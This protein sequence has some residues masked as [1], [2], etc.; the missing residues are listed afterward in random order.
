MQNETPGG[1]HDRNVDRSSSSA[2]AD[3]DEPRPE[4]R[5][6]AG[7]HESQALKQTA[8]DECLQAIVAIWSDEGG[9][10]LDDIALMATINSILSHRF[11]HFFWTG[12]Y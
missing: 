1:R 8:Y 11:P 2:P 12:F 4:A 6:A 3:R 7:A 5:A 10:T 9:S